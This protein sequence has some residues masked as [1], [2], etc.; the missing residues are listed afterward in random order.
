MSGIKIFNHSVRMVLGNSTQA[1]KVSLPML[2]VMVAAF[3]FGDGASGSAGFEAE[4]IADYSGSDIVFS[5]LSG[6]AGL[7][8]IV[9]WH[10]FILLEEYPASFPAFHGGQILAYFVNSILISLIIG[11]PLAIGVALVSLVLPVLAA[12][13][14]L[15]ALPVAVWVFYRLS[16][17]L[18]ASAIGNSISI[19]D[20]WEATHDI[21]GAAVIA[22]LLTFAAGMGLQLAGVLVFSIVP[23]VGFLGLI[24]ANW[25]TTL[26]FASLITTI[27]GI[28]VE[29]RSV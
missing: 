2:A 13:I 23:F 1:I 6:L 27:Y 4:D 8:A 5:F 9:A 21:S 17:M 28:A 14:A 7:W 19:K 22:A 26:I 15:A 25:A 20:A 3:I 11:I 18:A 29:N 10:R 12:V 16:P 24:A